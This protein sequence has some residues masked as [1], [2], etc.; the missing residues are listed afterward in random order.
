MEPAVPHTVVVGAGFGGLQA[1]RSLTQAGFPVTLIDRRS[2]HLFTPLLYQV[3][4]G[5]LSP[6]QIAVPIRSLFRDRDKIRC[7]MGE[8]CRIDLRQHEV[9]LENGE[10][11]AYNRLVIAAGAQSHFFGHEQEW[12]PRVHSLDD[13]RSAAALRDRFLEN[14][15]RAERTDDEAERRHLLSVAII[16]AGPSG[17][18]LAG[19]IAD[20]ANRTL[21]REYRNIKRGDV[22]VLLYEALDRVLPVFSRELSEKAA[23]QLKDLGVD[24]HLGSPVDEVCDDGLLVGGEKVRCALICWG[25]GVGPAKLADQIPGGSRKKGIPVGE[26]CSL[27]DHPEV[28]A[29][30]DIARQQGKD[31]K[32][33]PGLAPVALQQGRFVARMII[34]DHEGKPRERFR[35]HDK[36]LMATIGRAR[37]VLEAGSLR[38]SGLAAW[39]G[40]VI[41]HLYYLIGFRNR[42]LVLAEWVWSYVGAKQGNRLIESERVEPAPRADAVGGRQERR[43]LAPSYLQ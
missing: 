21:A 2:Y 30:G 11:I 37:A 6:S 19:A 43:E 27:A 42:I 8:V 25:S 16:G 29:V 18:E 22:R 31:G 32:P 14:C 4:T 41:L 23:L 7:L 34:A 35:Y 24:I 17:V 38:L 20:L 15:E 1:A 9:E 10:R 33:L 36:G 3:A 13:I 39:L 12:K 26:D 5:T 28:F 40:W